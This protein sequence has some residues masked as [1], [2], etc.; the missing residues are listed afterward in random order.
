MLF[1]V[2]FAVFF[3]CLIFE[4]ITSWI[5]IRRSKKYYPVL[6]EHAG[7]PTLMGNGD[8]VSAWPLTRYLLNKR[9]LEISCESSK[10]FAEK[11]RLPFLMGYFSA[12]V[13]VA[14]FFIVLFVFGSPA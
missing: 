9:Y 4:S 5:F 11:L 12:V 14:I 13:T 2:S 1:W 3:V 10:S 7:S 6:W 8:L